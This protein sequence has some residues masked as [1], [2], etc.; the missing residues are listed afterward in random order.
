MVRNGIMSG[1]DLQLGYTVRYGL[2][3]Q[4]FPRAEA[5]LYR[6][7]LLSSQYKYSIAQLYL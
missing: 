6:I 2:I 1:L 7:S 5:I 4:D 3:P